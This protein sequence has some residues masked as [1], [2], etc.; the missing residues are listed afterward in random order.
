VH[1]CFSPFG[2]WTSIRHLNT[3]GFHQGEEFKTIA[4]TNEEESRHDHD[5][6]AFAQPSDMPF[7]RHDYLSHVKPPSVPSD[8]LDESLDDDS[9]PPQII[10]HPMVASNLEDELDS[11]ESHSPQPRCVYLVKTDCEAVC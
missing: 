3:V 8:D 4:Q 10:K 11:A 5:C 7:S 2:S 9:D 1:S 6:T